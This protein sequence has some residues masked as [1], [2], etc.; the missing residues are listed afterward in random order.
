MGKQAG[1]PIIKRQIQRRMS[2][3][4]VIKVMRLK[5]LRDELGM[6]NISFSKFE[7]A[8]NSLIKDGVV[9]RRREA[10]VGVGSAGQEDRMFRVWL[11]RR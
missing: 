4:G 6:E 2:G 9:G 1:D 3:R 11:I 10:L 8:L 7:A 5:D